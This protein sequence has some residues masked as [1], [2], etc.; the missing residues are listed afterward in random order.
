M[1]F[2]SKRVLSLLPIPFF[3]NPKFRLLELVDEIFDLESRSGRESWSGTRGE[4]KEMPFPFDGDLKPNLGIVNLELG[5]RFIGA[6]F[7]IEEAAAYL[8]CRLLK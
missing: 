3:K 4:F 5:R 2:L 6:A 7:V 1:A 8:N